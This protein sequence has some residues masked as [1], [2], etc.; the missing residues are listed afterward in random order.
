VVF[1]HNSQNFGRAKNKNYVLQIHFEVGVGVCRYI[2]N[3]INAC[4]I[5]RCNPQPFKEAVD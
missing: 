1:S 5:G 3:E 4:E 2:K